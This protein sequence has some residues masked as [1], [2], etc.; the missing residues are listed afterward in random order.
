ME[1]MTS[2]PLGGSKLRHSLMKLSKGTFSALFE[3]LWYAT[4]GSHHTHTTSDRSKSPPDAKGPAR[5]N[6]SRGKV[7]SRI[8]S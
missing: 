8:T 5:L 1:S 7:A 3:F 2:A 4:I 6:S